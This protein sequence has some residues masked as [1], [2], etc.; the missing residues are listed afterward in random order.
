MI[1]YP[2]SFLG[3]FMVTF[4]GAF[5]QPKLVYNQVGYFENQPITLSV[6][7]SDSNS[8]HLE[9]PK[10]SQLTVLNATNTLLHSIPLAP[11][12]LC[13]LS[14]DYV[15][16]FQLPPL[17]AGSY[18]LVYG[19][20]SHTLFVAKS[21][22]DNLLKGVVKSY[23][24]QRTNMELTPQFAGKWHRKSSAQDASAFIHS[25]AAAPHLPESTV[26]ATP[27]GWYDAGDFGRYIVNSAITVYS[28]LKI[29]QDLP[30]YTAQLALDIPL[31]GMPQAPHL[32]HEV[33][34]NLEWMLSMQD[35][36]DGGVFHKV[37]TKH[38][39]GDIMP[40]ASVNPRFVVYKTT[41]ATLGFAASMAMA[42][43]VYKP[44]DSTFAQT[45][46]QAA[47]HA[48]AW[49][50]VHPA[51]NFNNPPDIH[52]G[53]YKVPGIVD[54][55]FWAAVEL[56]ITTQKSAYIPYIEQWMP[57]ES[58]VPFWGD[59]KSLGLWSILDYQALPDNAQISQIRQIQSKALAFVLTESNRIVQLASASPLKLGMTADN[60][61][62]GS[63][64]HAANSAMMLLQAHKHA[65]QQ[66][67]STHYIQTAQHFLDYITGRNPM[68]VCYITGYGVHSPMHIH[69]RA[70]LA[71][72]ILE[73]V[74]GLLAGGPHNGGQDVGSKTWQCEEYRNLKFP[75][76]SWIDHYCSYA[77]NEVAINWN[78]PLAYV[79]SYLEHLNAQ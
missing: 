33:R 47:V 1:Q 20:Q 59:V 12:A 37:S 23:Y 55:Q 19:T 49:A 27:K 11:G 22:Y 63:N 75:A 78:A 34:Y 41:T 14:G 58:T 73:P 79:L 43:R 24:F 71:D 62:W 13:A 44:F 2:L 74:P 70:S 67:Q 56:Y 61:V 46:L 48:F 17:P 54:E 29:A 31:E 36:V 64:S 26:I 6:L 25:S 9:N 7:S 8:S 57:T 53:Q 45:C 51:I 16:T 39:D 32:L 65:P 38:F 10:L 60:F 76:K 4:V 66:S 77:T 40:E 30:S 5:T 69:H 68:N 52:T 18:T 72:S 28:L 15:H 3:I 42:A 50:Q 35:T 21:P